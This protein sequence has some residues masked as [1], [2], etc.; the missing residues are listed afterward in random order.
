MGT[1]P[2]KLSMERGG[3]SSNSMRETQ[4]DPLKG[5]PPVPSEWS[6][7]DSVIFG[8]LLVLCGAVM[9]ARWVKLESLVSADPA[10]WLFQ[11]SRAAHGEM[12]YR[13]FSWNY[14]PLAIFLLGGFL[15]V[16]GVCFATAQFAI[17]FLSL[18]VVGLC[19]WLARCLLPRSLHFPIVTLVIA[20]GSTALTKFNLFSFLTYSPSL[21]LGA[22]GLFMLTIGGIRYLRS[23]VLDGWNRML[24][25]G[26][27]FITAISK[28]EA[29]AAALAALAILA[30]TDRWLWFRELPVRRWGVHYAKLLGAWAIP[31]AVTYGVVAYL[32]GAENLKAGIGGYGLATFACPW[33]PT[34]LGVFGAL[35]A[36]GQAIAIALALSIPFRMRFQARFGKLYRSMW[37][38]AAPGAAIYLSYLWYLNRPVLTSHLTLIQKV[39]GSLPT[40]LWTSPVLLPVMWAAICCWGFLALRFVRSRAR[41]VEKREVELLFLLTVPVVLS[42]RGLFGTTLFPYTEVSAICYPFFALLGPYLLWLWLSSAWTSTSAVGFSA[43]ASPVTLVSAVTL[44]YSLVRLVGGYPVLFSDRPYR[45]LATE[46]GIVKLSDNG[47]SAWI[48]RYVVEHTRP[49]DYV[50]DVPYGGGVNFAARRRSPLFTTQ[51]VQLRMPSHYLAGDLA[52][53]QAN[54]PKVVIADDQP[55]F[56]C[57]YGYQANMGCPF[58]RLVWEPD[59]PAWDPSV[60]LPVVT[61]VENHYRVERRANNKVLLVP[62]D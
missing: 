11:V 9:A 28:P 14:P 20:I 52:N 55:R 23:G 39:E 40:L 51:F 10:Y 58:P 41:P 13:D 50:L 62:V 22:I 7:G 8:S 15:K 45:P 54:P 57:T 1:E 6:R 21:H 38:V 60:A 12:P 25:A 34:G 42:F 3:Y 46:S 44:V 49:E 18:A 59:Q 24:V 26:G 31:A 48:Y 37:L 16:F 30:F 33:W 17:D 35:A 36:T 29:L 4:Q 43:W 5:V 2:L 61:Y 19:Y 32:V 27:A 53:I 47:V 56:G